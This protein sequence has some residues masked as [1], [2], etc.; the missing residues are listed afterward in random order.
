MER[1]EAKGKIKAE[2]MARISPDNDSIN[3][4]KGT[5]PSH[6]MADYTGS[7]ENKGYGVAKIFL[8]NDTA[9]VDY[10]EGG[11]PRRVSWNT[12]ITM[13][14]ASSPLIR[15]EKIKMQLS[16]DFKRTKRERYP[17]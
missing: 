12:I 2:A 7:Y 10:N 16:L 13:Y 1:T 9:W 11:S 8:E 5:T 6:A 3:Q 17:D 15:K 14:F 4:V